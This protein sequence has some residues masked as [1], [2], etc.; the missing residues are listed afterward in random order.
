MHLKKLQYIICGL[1]LAIVSNIKA[2]D[3]IDPG[4]DPPEP[5]QKY[6]VKVLADDADACDVSGT[7]QYMTGT[8][9]DINS[10]AKSPDYVFS[11]WTKNGSRIDEPASFQYTITSEN[12][13]FVAYYTYQ[14][15]EPTDPVSSDE[16]RLY[17]VSSPQG[18][19]SFNRTSGQKAEYDSYVELSTYG[20]QGYEFKGW[21]NGETK[22]TDESNF[23]FLMPNQNTTLTARFVYNPGNPNDP[24]S[25]G[26]DVQTLKTGD[27]NGDGSV[28][29]TDAVAVINAY[30]TT[31]Q[32][33]INVSLSDV[34]H[35]GIIDIT[36]AVAII[37]LYLNSQ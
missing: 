33:S 35:D 18:V 4:F 15:E 8:V 36:D 14:P 26:G 12:P 9:V 11:H 21:Y 28:D 25:A 34:N 29:V 17:L 13:T 20:N 23:M 1:L 16:Y 7:G 19:C 3:F 2:Q 10:S 22:V 30:L 6:S 27:A 31:D 24:T 32:S 37:N 5:L